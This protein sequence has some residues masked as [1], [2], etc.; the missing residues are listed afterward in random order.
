MTLPG[1]DLTKADA[2]T[3][4]WQEVIAAC[5]KK[6]CNS[7]DR[8]FYDHAREAEGNGDA[9]AAALFTFLGAICSFHMKLDTPEEPFAPAFEFQAGRSPSPE[10]L[11]EG[12]FQ[13][14][15]ALTPE[16]IDPEL[17]ARM[18]DILWVCRRNFRMALLAADAY[19]ASTQ[20]LEDPEHWSTGLHRVERAMQIAASLGRNNAALPKVI[21][22]IEERLKHYNGSDPL[23][24]SVKLME[25]LQEQRYGDP[26][27][28]APLAEK[29]ALQAEV[30]QK[31][32]K[33]RASWSVLAR[34]HR[35]ARNATLEREAQ[36]RLAETYFL[37]AQAV[38][39]HN[40]NDHSLVAHHLQQAIAALRRVSGTGERVTELHRQ[41]LNHQQQSVGQMQVATTSID[42]S[43]LAEQA[44]NAVAN[45]EPLQA[46]VSLALL[47]RP[48]SVTRL[49]DEV[50]QTVRSYPL[51]FLFSAVQLNEEGKVTARRPS[52]TP[53][54]LEADEALLRTEMFRQASWHRGTMATGAI[55]HARHQINLEHNIR[56]QDWMPIV[57]E[58]PF[59]PEGRELLYARGLHAGLIG[60]FITAIHVLIPQVEHSLRTLMSEAGLLVSGI[61]SAGI[62]DEHNINSL[63]YREELK[64]ILGEDMVF[65]LQG[66]LVER[67]GENIRNRSA[68]GL[69]S[70]GAFFTSPAIYLWWLILQLCCL[71]VVPQILGLSSEAP[72]SQSASEPESSS[73][74]DTTS[75]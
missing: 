66:L 18:A 25:L 71:P 12:H 68:H 6:E 70:S 38:L 42:V 4:A 45:K 74:K 22:Y 67:F 37:E 32:H 48:L 11:E 36:L 41:L 46:L 72:G 61:D 1:I 24:L 8:A 30:E 51:Q 56:I 73:S 13:L 40:S 63:L 50:R 54:D 60:D 20:R 15:L 7:Y 52:L 5:V 69:L 35:M 53:A 39:A 14:L 65:E 62:Q 34:W 10:D 58:N 19:L 44:R 3:I 16:T 26:G 75:S 55:E 64:A 33:A 57:A 27:V 43:E 59:I 2:D 31:W 49:R 23:F 17:Q 21:L 28:Y 9:K 29:I 47:S